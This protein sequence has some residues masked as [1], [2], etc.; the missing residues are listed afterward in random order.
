MR[1][2]LKRLDRYFD[3]HPIRLDLRIAIKRA[4]KG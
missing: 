2:L 3:T 1:I 4:V